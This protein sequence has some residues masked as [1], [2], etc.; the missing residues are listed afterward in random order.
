MSI[1]TDDNGSANITRLIG[2]DQVMDRMYDSLIEGRLHHGWIFSGEEGIG[3]F[4]LAQQIAGWLLS[5]P[6]IHKGLFTAADA[7]PPIR[8]PRD[9]PLDHPEARLVFAGAHPDMLVIQPRLDEKNRSGQ[10]KTEQIR[11]LAHFF[12]HSAA[13]GGWRVAIIDSL[14]VVNR[15]GLNAML[16]TLEEPPELSLIILLSSR[17]GQ[18]LPTIRSRTI[19]MLLP[20]LTMEQTRSVLTQIWE[21]E[22]SADIEPLSQISGGSPG[23]ACQLAEAE[24]LPLFEASCILLSDRK[25]PAVRFVELAEKWGSGGIRHAKIRAAG[26]YLFEGLLSLASLYAIEAGQLA[27][28]AFASVDFIA[29]AARHLATLHEANHLA[30]LHQNFTESYQQ[31]EAL[32]LDF[33]P[34]LAK[35]FSDLHSQ[36]ARK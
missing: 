26:Q 15:N 9:I 14:D 27:N 36:T 12:S 3:K 29:K 16:K 34:V 21:E 10:I 30:L 24:A 33:V 8:H 17:P 7:S 13:R 20:A 19:T 23:R 28:Q 6:P 1:Q 32:Y 22:D 31:N 2:H 25:T 18:L 5:Q 4:R 11:S 35:F